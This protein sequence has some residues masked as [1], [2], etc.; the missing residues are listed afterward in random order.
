MPANPKIKREVD[1][2]HLARIRKLP[3]IVKN[4]DTLL[5]GLLFKRNTVLI[6]RNT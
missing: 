3:C 1:K 2:K 6:L 4:K 5:V